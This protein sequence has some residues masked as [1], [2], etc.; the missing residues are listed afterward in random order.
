MRTNNILL[1]VSVSGLVLILAVNVV[2][3]PFTS[4]MSEQTQDFQWADNYG[5][6]D[7]N[8]TI[9][10][11]GFLETPNYDLQDGTSRTSDPL[12]WFN[13]T[14]RSPFTIQ[15]N[16]TRIHIRVLFFTGTYGGIKYSWTLRWRAYN[17]T[18]ALSDSWSYGLD[19]SADRPFSLQNDDIVY[20]VV[21]GAG[22]SSLYNVGQWVL[23]ANLV[24]NATLLRAQEYNAYYNLRLEITESTSET[25]AGFGLTQS[26]FPSLIATLMMASVV[27][28]QLYEKMKK[29]RLARND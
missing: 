18:E 21:R 12:G 29:P 8:S 13:M 6:Y 5:M 2:F 11:Y 20:D 14:L 4:M 25:R 1:L 7:D 15:D 26:F 19:V 16:W 17:V 10:G 27:S 23:E 9:Y 3:P 22:N 24:H 28:V